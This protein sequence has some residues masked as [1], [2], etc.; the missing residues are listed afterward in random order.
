MDSNYKNEIKIAFKCEVQT[1][2]YQKMAETCKTIIDGWVKRC[3]YME[4]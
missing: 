3:T 2:D 4:K 1:L